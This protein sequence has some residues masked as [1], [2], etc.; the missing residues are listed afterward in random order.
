[1]LICSRH[2]FYIFEMWFFS[3]IIMLL[4]LVELVKV[5]SVYLVRVPGRLYPTSL[6]LIILLVLVP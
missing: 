3:S 6:S 1:M 2:F 4:I 5:R